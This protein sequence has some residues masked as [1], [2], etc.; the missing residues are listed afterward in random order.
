MLKSVDVC[1][2]EVTMVITSIARETPQI[3]F[4]LWRASLGPKF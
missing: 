2:P 1:S 3:P 4:S